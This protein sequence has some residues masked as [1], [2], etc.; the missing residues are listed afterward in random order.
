MS[1]SPLA[2]IKL[3]I[4][5]F[6]QG[7]IPSLLACLADDAE[8]EYGLCS[9]NVPWCQNRRGVQG[10]TEFFQRLATLNTAH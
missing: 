10:T 8:W 1:R 5:A 9:Q 7:D 2:T 6:A 3:I 4:N